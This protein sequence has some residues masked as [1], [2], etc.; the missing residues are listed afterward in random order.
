MLLY[1]PFRDESIEISI[2]SPSLKAKYTDNYESILAN[3]KMFERVDSYLF[4]KAIDFIEKEVVEEYEEQADQEAENINNAH[5]AMLN[6]TSDEESLQSEKS[7]DSEVIEC[8]NEPY[9]S[10]EED[11]VH[12]ADIEALEEEYGFH[13]NIVQTSEERPSNVLPSAFNFQRAVDYTELTRL[14]CKLN[15][16]QRVILQHCITYLFNQDKFYIFLAGGAGTGKSRVINTL[17]QVLLKIFNPREIAER[18]P[19]LISAYTGKA[20]F[21]VR[22]Y[23]LHTL[24]KIPIMIP[25]QFKGMMPELGDNTLLKLQKAFRCTQILIVDEISMVG[26]N[27]WE[28]VSKRLMQIKC[29]QE[30]FGGL[31]ILVVGDFNQVAPV[32]EG[33]IFRKSKQNPYAALVQTSLWSL[34]KVNN[35]GF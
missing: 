35:C 24:F 12:G 3:K 11:S 14:V 8:D 19:V 29:N 4:D 31:S 34:F 32:K 9:Y 13:N 20:A 21:N 33:S 7:L 17:Y 22:G 6:Y 26:C 27:L 1:L 5:E 2:E 30:P 28:N 16:K 25:H 18:L 10:A 15:H 23:T